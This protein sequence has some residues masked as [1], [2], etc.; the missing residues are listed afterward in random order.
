MAHCTHERRS[1]HGAPRRWP[2]GWIDRPALAS[3]VAPASPA[4][5]SARRQW[6]GTAK[7]PPRPPSSRMPHVSG[8]R[9]APPSPPLR[10][11]SPRFVNAPRI[12]MAT[13]SGLAC[14]KPRSPRVTAIAPAPGAV[15][16]RL[17][18]GR[19]MLDETAEPA[20]IVAP[21]RCDG[22]LSPGRLVVCMK[23]VLMPACVAPPRPSE[24]PMV[25]ISLT[26]LPRIAFCSPSLRS[27]MLSSLKSIAPEPSRS[28]CLKSILS[29]ASFIGTESAANAR[30]SSSIVTEPSR[31]L[32]HR[33]K[34]STTRV[35]LAPI[36]SLSCCTAFFIFHAVSICASSAS[37]AAARPSPRRLATLVWSSEILG[38]LR[39][40][41]SITSARRSSPKSTSPE[42]SASM[43]WMI[44][45]SERLS[46]TGTL[47]VAS[48]FCSSNMEMVPLP[49]RS[50]ERK[51]SIS[52]GSRAASS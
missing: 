6:G 23:V 31:S 45:A 43:I 39:L 30:R 1:H 22:P 44:C 13:P 29:A 42:P 8:A 38:A 4:E 51:T 27:T 18:V 21:G 16:L 32:S 33:A 28:I 41:A 7:E 35:I 5:A 40:G 19:I 50:H 11:P 37:L 48:A 2:R 14:A 24:R 49:S 10:S 52:A 15:L 46:A 12:G 3:R 9:S 36:T 20:V 25:E 26:R 34:T 17:S 47:S